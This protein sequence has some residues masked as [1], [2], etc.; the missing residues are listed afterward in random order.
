[1]QRLELL[2]SLNNKLTRPLRAAGSQVQ[3][4]AATSRAAFGQIAIGGAALW[5]VGHAIKG[6]LQPAI[7]MDRALGEVRSLGVAESGLRKLQ[8]ASLDFTMAYGGN[9]AEFVRSS[10]DIQSAIAGLTDNE[11]S[12]FTAASATL[13]RATKSSSATITAYMGTMYGIF[14]QQANAMGRGA[15]VEQIAGQTA[16]AVQMF[17]TT[18]DQMSAA[19]TSLG[20]SATAA[21]VDVAEQFAVLGQLQ[22]TMSGSEA[23]TKYRAF[24]AGIG[25]AQTTLGLN[26]TRRDGTMKGITEIMRLIQGKF[27]DLSKVTDSDLLAKAFG[28]KQAV[29]MVKLLNANIGNLEKNITTLGNSRG[30]GKAAE[31]AGAM[32]DPWK[33]SLAVINAMRIEIGTQLLPVLYPFID[34][35]VSGGREFIKWLQLYP[36]ITRAIGLM[37]VAMLALAAAGA[38]VNITLGVMRFVGSGLKAAFTVLA[39]AFRLNAIGTLISASATKVYAMALRHLRAGMLASSIAG[40]GLAVSIAMVTWPILLIGAAIAG[41]VLLVYKFWQ[42]IRAFFSGFIQG[43]SDAWVELSKGSPLFTIMARGIAWVW[44]GVKTLFGWLSGLFTPIALTGE[45]FSRV[46]QAGASFGRIAA[47]AV[48]A[49]LAPL[50]MITNAL[51]LVWDAIV[52]IGQGWIDIWEAIDI[53]NPLQSMKR[54]AA[55]ILNIFGNLWA[56]VKSSFSSAYNWIIEKLNLIPGVSIEMQPIPTPDALNGNAGDEATPLLTAGQVQSAGPGGIGQQIRNSNNSKTDIDQSVR[57]TTF[58]IASASAGDI[59][60][61]QELYAR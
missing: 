25:G 24:L 36:N 53:E 21:G 45:Q 33:Q 18:G 20:A 31:M 40:R 61:L 1:M 50:E 7:E 14:E 17:K 47:A 4:F 57:T 23:G 10:Y 43:F 8:R 49:I 22:A 19:F 38:V 30:M 5:G 48:S 11:L 56:L 27:G 44:S 60:E 34:Q 58:N 3:A 39:W 15:W 51:G 26:F 32:A 2:L 55:G 13:A 29:A 41:V 54:I 16:T 59:R 9:A 35:A 52:I 37:A 12:R 6:A 42:P 46:S 28:S